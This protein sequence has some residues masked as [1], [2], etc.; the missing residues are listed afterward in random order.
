MFRRAIA[1][2]WQLALGSLLLVGCAFASWVLVFLAFEISPGLLE[3]V[4]LDGIKYYA[5]KSRYVSDPDLVFTYRTSG[6]PRRSGSVFLGDVYSPRYGAAPEPVEY[7]MTHDER[8]FRIGSSKPPYDI[9]VIGDSYV[10][11]GE[12]DDLTFPELLRAATGMSVQSLGR[13]WYG[14]DQYVT[15]LERFAV[16]ERPQLALFCFFAGNDFD[17]L[18]HFDQW[19]AGGQYHFYENLDSLPI[20]K[21]F[22]R[23]TRETVEFLAARLGLGSRDTG[24]AGVD[25]SRLGLIDLG[26]GVQLMA[27]TYW[28]REI[29]PH[30]LDRLR[31]VLASFNSTAE[32]AGIEVIIVYIP[33]ATQIY[34]EMHTP[35]SNSAFIERVRA[36]P[37]NPSRN[38][39]LR[40]SGELDLEVIDLLPEF[41]ALASEGRLLYYRFDTHWNVEGR[42]AAA[43]AIAARLSRRQRQQID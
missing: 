35:E 14:P 32:R 42:R 2:L 12:R 31:S 28:E 41:A 20:W 43:N 21:R 18:W 5:L 9:S 27:L 3:K 8:G 34:A 36:S 15:L 38:A 33:T 16:P 22:N 13:G 40:V 19:R 6:R 10:E 7:S 30:Q 26:D 29:Y 4:P 11:F 25:D 24:P 39:V 37:G 23:S 1:R 17:D